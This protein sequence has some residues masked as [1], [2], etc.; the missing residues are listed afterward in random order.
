MSVINKQ[1]FINQVIASLSDDD[2]KAIAVTD[3]AALVAY[4]KTQGWIS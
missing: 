3:L 2:A 4:A 1:P